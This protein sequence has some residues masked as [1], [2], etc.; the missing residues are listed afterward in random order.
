MINARL[1]RGA[2]VMNRRNLKA[3]DG[4]VIVTAMLVMSILLLIGLGLAK[5]AD[6]QSGLSGSERVRETSFNLGEGVLSAQSVV[7][8]NN[9][10]IKAPC[11]GNT[12][13]C[14]Y[15]AVC[16]YAAGALTGGTALTNCPKPDEL[17]GANKAFAGL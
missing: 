4:W 2:S 11:A 6:T 5:I 9:W 10:P 12:K 17:I 1:S 8:Q 15:P 7:L 13:G 3:Q 16:T 14:G